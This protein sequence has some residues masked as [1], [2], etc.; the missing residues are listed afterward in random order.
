MRGPGHL[1]EE[2]RPGSG[3]GGGGPALRLSDLAQAVRKVRHD[4]N[5]P[6]GAAFAE[7]QLLLMD[8][9][10]PELRRPL[11]TIE[12]QLRRMRDRLASLTLPSAE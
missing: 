3:E 6:L 9:V 8:V 12:E 1:L 7:V 11:E 2:I 4:V 10:D 5:N